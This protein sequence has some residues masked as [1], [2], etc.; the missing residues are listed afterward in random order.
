[1]GTFSCPLKLTNIEGDK[2][3]E[4]DAVVDTGAFFTVVPA[5]ILEQI[6]VRPEK[7]VRLRLADGRLDSRDIAEARVH[8]D[9]KSA[10]TQ[11]VFGSND[12]IVLL[13]SLTL[14]SLLLTVDPVGQRLVPI[15]VIPV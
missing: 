9:G 14:E 8:I 12:S 6:G 4:V 2:S 1:M 10:I 5:H 11:V 13:G 7:V 15:E 3:V